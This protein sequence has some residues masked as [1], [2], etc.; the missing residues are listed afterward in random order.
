MNIKVVLFFIV[1]ILIAAACVYIR[2]QENETL[3]APAQKVRTWQIEA[4]A[5]VVGR[6]KTAKIE[7]ELPLASSRY[8]IT[9]E[10]F[11]SNGFAVGIIDT[12]DS[13]RAVWS[14]F[15]EKDT[16]LT[17]YY[18]AQV[19][20]RD[21]P[22]KPRRVSGVGGVQLNEELHRAARAVTVSLEKQRLQGREL[23]E[24]LV[25]EVLE[26]E[27]SEAKKLLS[28][29]KTK[30]DRSM[31]IAEVLRFAGFPARV[32]HGIE[33]ERAERSVRFFPWVEAYTGEEWT[34]LNL[35]SGRTRVPSRWF[36]WWRDE[37]EF[38]ATR[39]VEE[40]EWMVSVLP[41]DFAPLR[42][43]N[44][45]SE[46]QL[47]SFSQFPI[48][49]QA[50]FRLIVAVPVGALVVAFLRCIVGI[51]TIGT[52][53]PVLIALSFR[54]TEL[55]WGLMLYLGVILFSLL[56][57]YFF[58]HLQLLVVPRL[59]ATLTLVVLVMITFTFACERFEISKG[60]SVA[61]FP[62]VILTMMV[63]RI[64]IMFEEIGIVKSLTQT[65]VTLSVSALV[66]AV[67]TYDYVSYYMFVFPELLLV[68]LSLAILIGRYSGYRLTELYRFRS[69]LKGDQ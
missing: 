1:P 35:G 61:L 32:V 52:F 31:R 47:F 53:M 23:V 12:P 20:L 54:E 9:S 15:I 49:S 60:L 42:S 66:Y 63:E 48:G 69:F 45:E 43:K 11:V 25:K 39:G 40:S 55:L 26:G 18:R 34:P 10:N 46:S 58:E 5:E 30:S 2:V 4:R 19:Q 33:L 8:E 67:L 65:C 3:L 36:G 21:G 59:T 22:W 24:A 28:G 57:R 64:S 38:V 14:G 29:V 50:V 27:S 44:S 62:I 13:R 6:G 37:V 7:L 56:G 17:F 41:L 16:E 68:I 51:K